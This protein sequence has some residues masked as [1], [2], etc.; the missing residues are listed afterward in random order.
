MTVQPLVDALRTALTGAGI[1]FGDGRMP[2]GATT[3]YIV[4]WFDDGT[5]TDRSL[6]S[7]DG[8]SA[9]G[10]FHCYGQTPEA[11]RYAYRALTDAAL[12]LHGQ[13]VG[14]RT[15]L[16]PEQLTSLPLSRDDD[17]DPP[18]FDQI[19]EWRFRTTP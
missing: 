11:A 8:W 16:M 17:L 13:T 3:R 1:A 7:R 9:V 2:N 18:L 14:G 5:V 12:G 10:T 6:L 19:A 15:V 4:A